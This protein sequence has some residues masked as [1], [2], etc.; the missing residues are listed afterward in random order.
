MMCD[1]W[2]Y[3]VP[4]MFVSMKVLYNS[5]KEKITGR[6]QWYIHQRKK[7]T[8][9][10]YRKSCLSRFNCPLSLQG[11]INFPLS[12]FFL[13]FKIIQRKWCILIEQVKYK[14]K[15]NKKFGLIMFKLVLNLFFWIFYT[16]KIMLDIKKYILMKTT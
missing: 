12:R 13:I 6:K 16:L 1:I 9:F 11:F 5:C 14:R 8:L 15:W 3:N 2:I 4:M 10:E 7:S